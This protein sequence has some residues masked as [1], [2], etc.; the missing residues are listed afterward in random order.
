VQEEK[1][2]KAVAFGVTALLYFTA[3]ILV[4]NSLKT[5]WGSRFLPRQKILPQE[6]RQDGRSPEG[7]LYGQNALE[8]N[9]NVIIFPWYGIVP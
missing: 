3:V 4:M 2:D 6:I 5:I 9:L 1:K 8:K 7:R